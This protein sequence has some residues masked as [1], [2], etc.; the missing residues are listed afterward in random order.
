[1]DN[2]TTTHATMDHEK[3]IH[4][5]TSPPDS[6]LHNEDTKPDTVPDEVDLAAAQIAAMSPE[7]YAEAERLLLKK[8]DRNI[9]PWITWVP[10]LIKL[11]A[12]CCIS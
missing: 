3:P 7:E 12:V 2:E 6:S 4:T 10:T 5:S 11:M 8:L 1:M 9:V